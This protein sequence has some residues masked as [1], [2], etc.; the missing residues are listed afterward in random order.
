MQLQ[1]AAESHVPCFQ[2]RVGTSIPG[3]MIPDR[4]PWHHRARPSATLHEIQVRPV[5]SELV[6]A[7]LSARSKLVNTEV[8]I[9]VGPGCY[10]HLAHVCAFQRLFTGLR[11]GASRRLRDSVAALARRLFNEGGVS[12]AARSPAFPPANP[13]ERR[14]SLLRAVQL[15]ANSRFLT[16]RG[17]TD[18]E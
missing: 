13:P 14:V 17:M 8:D 1:L 3:Y 15:P 18:S 16:S 4:L 10:A 7:I 5:R 6:P 12:N 9:E 11:F 2:E